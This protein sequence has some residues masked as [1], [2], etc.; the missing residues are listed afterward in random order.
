MLIM[1]CVA[2]YDNKRQ[3]HYDNSRMDMGAIVKM[4]PLGGKDLTAL[5]KGWRQNW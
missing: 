4:M 1:P 3:M 5:P 2:Y